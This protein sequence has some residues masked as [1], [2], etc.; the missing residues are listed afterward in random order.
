LKVSIFPD[1]NISKALSV[2]FGYNE[3]MISRYLEF[4]PSLKECLLAMEISLPKYIRINTLKI[5][6]Y[7]LIQRLVKKDVVCEETILDDVLLIKKFRYPIGAMTEY[8]LGYYYIQ[9]LTSCLAVEEL[10]ISP[11]QFNLDMA[12]APG[13]KT[14][15]I[16]Q[17]MKNFGCVVALEPSSRRIRALKFNLSRCGV[18][19]T[20][21]YKLDG[22]FVERLGLKF[23]RIL[24]DAPCSCEGIIAKDPLIKTNLIPR[25]IESCMLRQVELLR[26]AIK[27]IK[28]GGLIIY[29]TCTFAPEENEL[30]IN[31][32]LE[33]N[34]NIKI[35]PQKFGE[36]GLIKYG[37]IKLDNRLVDTRRFYPHFHNT[38]GFFI[39]KIR[40]LEGE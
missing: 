24:L 16:S 27:V 13:G 20:C 12:S 14:S 30:V 33:T 17:K 22:S 15:F 26:S 18:S 3:W 35:E 9:D 19:N 38:S 8:L 5:S 36:R 2:E 40:V 39:A 4:I 31:N 21:I 34:T 29:S 6:K 32:L 23:D 28:P 7:D 37:D 25:K 11:N 1:S 10:D